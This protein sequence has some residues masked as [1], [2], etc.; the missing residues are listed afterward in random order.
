MLPASAR[1]ARLRRRRGRLP[2]LAAV[3][4]LLLLLLRA[5]Q[6]ASG[7]SHAYTWQVGALAQ[8]GDVLQN[9]MTLDDAKSQCN[10]HPECCGVTFESPDKLPT[11]PLKMFLKSDCHPNTDK[12]WNTY[13]KGEE[14]TEPWAYGVLGISG[15]LGLYVGLGLMHGWLVRGQR[16]VN[17]LPNRE[18]ILA[19]WGLVQDGA[20]FVTGGFVG[21]DPS[22]GRVPEHGGGGSGGSGGHKKKSSGKHKSSSRR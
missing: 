1:S 19:V 22:Y 11:G 18:E 10:G 5:P 8:G 7:W 2:S 6:P 12:A 3:T 9:E 13:I 16:G 20:A 17:A 15:F 4:V 14:L 21:N